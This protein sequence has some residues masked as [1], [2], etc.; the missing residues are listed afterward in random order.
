MIPHYFKKRWLLSYLFIFFISCTNQQ[1]KVTTISFKDSIALQQKI[2]I[3]LVELQSIKAT[4]QAGDIITR[5][6]NDFTSQSLKKLN[7]RDET[8][9]HIGI[10]NIE[11]NQLYIYHAIG[12]EWNPNQQIKKE[13]F[14]TFTNPIDNN[15]MG[16]YRFNINPIAKQYFI[17]KAINF[18]QQKIIFDLDFD[19]KT[20]DKMYCAEYVYK[21]FV[22]SKNNE[23]TFNHSHIK[24]FEFIGV[25]DITLH[26]QC[27]NI[28]LYV[29]K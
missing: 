9:S 10:A 12:G 11:N 15:A 28:L 7:R 25:D 5:E 6:G 26:P 4:I 14:E 24:Q 23:L 8:F 3:N 18:Y 22:Q 19:L 16:I 27:K 29:Y 1:N 17:E 20:N 2:K 13:S 21:S